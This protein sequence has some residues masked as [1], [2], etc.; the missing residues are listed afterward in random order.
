V[1]QHAGNLLSIL[2]FF[3]WIPIAIY[4]MRRWP[5]AKATAVLCLGGLLLLPE[6]VAFKLPAVPEFAKEDI[7]VTWVFI[8]AFL[9]HRERLKAA[10]SSWQ[11]RLCVGLLLVGGCFTVLLN[12]DPFS[13]GSVYVPGHVPY[14]AVHAMVA[15]VLGIALPF[16]LGAAMFRNGSDLRVLLKV[17]VAAGL[18]YSLLQLVEL[19]FSPQVH[20]WVYGFAQHHF[21]QTMRGGGYRPMVFMEH[22]LAVALFTALTVIAAAVLQKIKADVFRLPAV[23]AMGYLWVILLFSKSVAAFLYSLIAVPLVLFASPRTQALTALALG[24]VLLA[25]PAARYSGM[26]PVDDI[27]ALVMEEYGADK[28]SSVMTRFENEEE[29]LDRAVKRPW[30]G[31]G[32]YCRVCLFEPWDGKMVSVRDGAWLIQLGDNGIVGFV[33]KFGLLI[34]P[35]FV[36]AR[37]LKY[38]PRESDRRLLAALGLMVGF[39]AFDLIPNG[40]YNWLAFVLSGALFGCVTGALQEALVDGSSAPLQSRP[41]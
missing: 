17:L 19:R 16:Y 34:F 3:I 37:R 9:F 41:L 6:L 10:P 15:A 11:F 12:S 28:V 38:V 5:P 33:G 2:A 40:N 22:G 8:G 20:N 29:M 39:S 1:I 24:T 27:R 31:W 21:A 35:L 7:V 14:D 13:V 18:L 4:G 25:Y 30:F 32:S 26:I 23:W 36:L